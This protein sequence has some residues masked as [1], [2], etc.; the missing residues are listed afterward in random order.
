MEGTPGRP[1]RTPTLP[2]EGLMVR[3][4]MPT[5]VICLLQLDVTA[6]NLPSSFHVL[7]TGRRED[8]TASLSHCVKEDI[9]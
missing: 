2:P 7:L 1:T 3:V 6:G 8:D 4:M 9:T 5:V